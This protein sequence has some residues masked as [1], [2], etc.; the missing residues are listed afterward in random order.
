MALSFSEPLNFIISKM[1]DR[2]R[3]SLRSPFT[4][5]IHGPKIIF[6]LSGNN[7]SVRE[8]KTMSN[9]FII[10]KI[11]EYCTPMSTHLWQLEDNY[12]ASF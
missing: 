12:T 10:K 6:L 3:Q 11:W 4:Q 9:N 8:C 2:A 1:R 7:K 5:T